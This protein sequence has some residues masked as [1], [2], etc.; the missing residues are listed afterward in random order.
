MGQPHQGSPERPAVPPALRAPGERI[1]ARRPGQGGAGIAFGILEAGRPL[2]E[3]RH[4]EG[5]APV[6]G[7]EHHPRG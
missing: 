6:Q 4:S 7:A 1:G 2:C 3:D 5:Q